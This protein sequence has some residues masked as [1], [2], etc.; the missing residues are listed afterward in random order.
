MIRRDPVE[1]I[2]MGKMILEKNNH[3]KQ[4]NGLK[5]LSLFSGIGGIDL[6]FH[7]AGFD[8]VAT[9]DFDTKTCNTLEVNKGKWISSN[10]KIVEGDITKIKPEG[11]YEGEVDFIV[12]GPP[13]QSFSAIGRRAGGALG[14][15]DIRGGLFEHYCRLLRHYKPKGFLFENVRGILYANKG[16]DWQRVLEAFGELGYTLKYRVLDAAGFGVAQHRERVILVGYRKGEFQFPRPTHGP[17]SLSKNSFISAQL[18]FKGLGKQTESKLEMNGGKYD[19]LLNDIPPGMNY[20][21]YTEKMGHK[22]PQFAWRSKFSDFLYK[23][24]PD[25]PTKTLVAKMGRYSGPFH[26]ENRRLSVSELKRLQGFPDDFVITG[27]RAQQIQ[28]IGNSVVPPMAYSLAL[29]TAKSLFGIKNKVELLSNDEVLY[30]DRRKGEKAASTRKKTRSNQRNKS[31]LWLFHQNKE[32]TDS[33]SIT[34]KLPEIGYLSYSKGKVTYSQ[35]ILLNSWRM[36]ISNGG[37]QVLVKLSKQTKKRRNEDETL[38]LAVDFKDQVLPIS[39]V[40][41]TLF[42]ISPEEI[43]VVWDT[44]NYIIKTVSSYPSIHELY[45]HFTEPN[46]RFNITTKSTIHQ[47][48]SPYIALFLW[49]ANLQR[50]NELHQLKELNNLGLEFKTEK[51]LVTKL[52]S[53]RFDIRTNLTNK[54]IPK[55]MFRICYPYTLPHDR[56]SFVTIQNI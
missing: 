31:Q 56:R 42:T 1:C 52:R 35:G 24:N 19:H 8:I 5:V 34:N 53:M 49:T 37:S 6:G 20:L 55:G 33:N 22:N 13:C 48:I 54:Q 4:K 11:L 12:G 50:V 29:A 44:I 39:T 30:I 27:S 28:Q 32:K 43:Y 41:I 2:I 23:A 25:A 14:T 15:K 26:W 21:F 9:L 36:N 16:K 47:P 38:E 40:K 18:A 51:E 3:A 45:G 17:D 10:T 46:P 7:L